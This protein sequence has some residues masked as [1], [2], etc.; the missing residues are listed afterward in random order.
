MAMKETENNKRS[1]EF[2]ALV[3]QARSEQARIDARAG[4]P[5]DDNDPVRGFV[6]NSLCV[7]LPTPIFYILFSVIEALVGRRLGGWFAFSV[8]AIVAVACVKVMR[9]NALARWVNR[10]AGFFL[11]GM[12]LL[13]ALA[14]FGVPLALVFALLDLRSRS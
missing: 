10:A 9:N 6:V 8:L 4:I 5:H 12:G 7:L 14:V 1:A 2:D 11:V 13:V 3:Q